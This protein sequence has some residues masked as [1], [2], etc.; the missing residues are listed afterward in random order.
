MLFFS[1]TKNKKP[2]LFIIK[3]L[4]LYI[5]LF[6]FEKKEKKA[7]NRTMLHPQSDN[8]LL[9]NKIPAIINKYTYLSI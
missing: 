3:Y 1:I 2:K 9:Q 7:S 8:L 6:F 4:A 5:N